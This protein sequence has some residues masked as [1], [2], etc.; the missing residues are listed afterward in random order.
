M[1]IS[2]IAHVAAGCVSG[3][4]LAQTGAINTTGAD[5]IFIVVSI[6]GDFGGSV[7]QDNKSNIY[8]PCTPLDGTGANSCCIFYCL[9]PAVGSGH[10]FNWNHGSAFPSIYVLACSGV[11]QTSPL[12]Q[13]AKAQSLTPGSITPSQ[14]GE[15]VI[16]GYC[17][18]GGSGT[19]T[20]GSGFTVSDALA[21]LTS[22]DNEGGG[23]AYLIQTTATAANPSWAT[24]T[25]SPRSVIASFKGVSSGPT[26]IDITKTDSLS[27]SDSLVISIPIS[28][29]TLSDQI[30][31]QDQLLIGQGLILSESLNLSDFLQWGLSLPVSIDGDQFAFSDAMVF[32]RGIGLGISDSITLSDVL[33]IGAGV[34]RMLGDN[35]LLS[36]FLTT[37]LAGKPIYSDNFTLSDSAKIALSLG[38]TQSDS[39]TLSDAVIIAV[40]AN[41]RI[42]QSDSL[43]LSDSV[44]LNLSGALDSYIRHY[45]NDVPR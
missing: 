12:D 8:I 43:S 17:T 14:D 34:I 42:T 7:P 22:G 36:D 1:A 29:L 19:P 37:L 28:N 40:I 30:I 35:V 44:E 21:F 25:S 20:I 13:E 23:L 3:D 18:N 33:K 9:A 41:T 38:L 31:L 32:L 11:K 39:F 45:L 5:C 2:A 24:G 4:N 27:L 6:F 15:I 26:E 16:T 10:T